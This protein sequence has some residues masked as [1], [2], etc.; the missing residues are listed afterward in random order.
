MAKGRSFSR[1]RTTALVRDYLSGER[2]HDEN[3]TGEAIDPNRGDYLASIH[4]HL[5]RR[6]KELDP[7]YHRPRYHSFVQLIRHLMK[8]KLVE[9]T[10]E[11]ETSDV[12]VLQGDPDGGGASP[13]DLRLDPARGFQQRCYWCLTP[14]SQSDPA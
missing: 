13:G 6:I 1:V 10:G 4:R 2:F 7:R 8:L 14:D 9:H 3:G 11:T 12:L 5:K